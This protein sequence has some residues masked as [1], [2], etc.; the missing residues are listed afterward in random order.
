VVYFTGGMDSFTVLT[1][2]IQKWIRPFIALSFDYGQKHSKE[3]EWAA[4]VLQNRFGVFHKV[5]DITANQ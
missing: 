2:H 5:V 4:Q 3:L 1:Q